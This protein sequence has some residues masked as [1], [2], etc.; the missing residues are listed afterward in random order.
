LLSATELVVDVA[1]RASATLTARALI[2]KRLE[3]LHNC[4]PKYLLTTVLSELYRRTV[5]G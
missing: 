3:P 4:D 5:G 1:Q 2:L